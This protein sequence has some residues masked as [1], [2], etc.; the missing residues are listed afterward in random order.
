MRPLLLA[1]IS[2]AILFSAASCSKKAKPEELPVVSKDSRH[3]STQD[4]GTVSPRMSRGGRRGMR[5]VGDRSTPPPPAEPSGS[6]AE[7]ASAAPAAPP[8]EPVDQAV[9]D[10]L[11]LLLEAAH[12]ADTAKRQEPWCTAAT[13]YPNAVA[14]P[15]PE[16]KWLGLSAFVA[17]DPKQ[18]ADLSKVTDLAVLHAK[19][20]PAEASIT[21]LHAPSGLSKEGGDQLRKSLPD[22]LLKGPP[23]KLH[24]SEK[25]FAFFETAFEP[26]ETKREALVKHQSG[27]SFAHQDLRKV[28]N[29]WVATMLSEKDKKPAGMR[30]SVFAS[31]PYEK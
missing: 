11:A 16:G 17:T 4:K 19:T 20:T 29:T 30:F 3:G 25:D 24:V 9:K 5:P 14:A 18:N 6:P 13:G 8:K 1:P 2:I 12:C 26:K 27:F 31:V 28:G 10:H 15:L 21:E 23:E 22:L 7:S